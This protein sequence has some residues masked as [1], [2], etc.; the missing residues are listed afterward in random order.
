M[1]RRKILRGTLLAAVCMAVMFYCG[2]VRS[3]SGKNA[4]DQTVETVSVTVE[5]PF[6]AAPAAENPAN[7]ASADDTS[8][9]GTASDT[10]VTPM[11]AQSATVNG[12]KV[13]VRSKASTAGEKVAQVNTGTAVTVTGSAEDGGGKTWYQVN[14]INNGSD[15]TGFIREDMLDLG[16]VVSDAPE[17]EG[18]GEEGAANEE[19][20]GMYGDLPTEEEAEEESGAKAEYELTFSA[21]P[22]DGLEYWYLYDYKN[23]K[24]YKVEQL[25]QVGMQSDANMETLNKEVSR[26]KIGIIILAV[27]LVLAVGMAGFFGFR[28]H[29]MSDEYEDDDDDDDDD[30]ED[31]DDDIRRAS[32]VRRRGQAA[33]AA[34]QRSRVP[35]GSGRSA[36]RSEGQRR[37][38]EGTQR[39][40]AQSAA[41]RPASEGQGKRA[42]G[43]GSTEAVRRRPSG[44]P[45][46]TGASRRSPQSG[47]SVRRAPEAKAAPRSTRSDVEWKSKNFL[48]GDED[49]PDF[50]F[51]NADDEE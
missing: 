12:D 10:D 31:D 51:I 24:R 9:A 16:E 17:G 15:V 45:Q 40:P 28:W 43:Q 49:A 11:A 30:D 1:D 35:A 7:E 27:L 5:T 41:R 13:N 20:A 22:S 36:V 50:S 39:R 4:E 2:C 23:Q 18:A 33:S 32:S 46:A 8:A 3:D 34:Q 44:E 14:F 48:A 19:L 29:E 37:P 6:V 21:D 26:L 38:A 42:P 47:Q 25:L